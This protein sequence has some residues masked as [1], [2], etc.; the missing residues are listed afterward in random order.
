MTDSPAPRYRLYVI[1]LGR[2]PGAAEQPPV[3]VGS[4]SLSR[5][6][7]WREHRAGGFTA[8]RRVTRY[9]TRR[10]PELARGTGT[11]PTRD[12]AEAAEHRLRCDLEARGYRVFG[13]SGRPMP[14]RGPRHRAIAGDGLSL[15]S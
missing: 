3:Y 6:Q 9:G 14:R 2:F 4:T 15:P 11:Y 10:L 8:S 13:A 1:D 12:T 7:R 5:R